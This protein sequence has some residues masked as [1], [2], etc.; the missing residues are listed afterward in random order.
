[1]ATPAFGSDL[2]KL[3]YLIDME[4]LN[5]LGSPLSL[6]QR[7]VKLTGSVPSVA[8]TFVD[9][10]VPE[11]V[12]VNLTNL[13]LSVTD[14]VQKAMYEAMTQVTAAALAQILQ[15]L[16]ITTPN[17]TTMADLLNPYILFP[18]SFQSLTVPTMNGPRAIYINATGSVNT[19]LGDTSVTLTALPDYILSSGV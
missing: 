19:K 1:L 3:G 15:V 6:I 12:V 17:I 16:N 7:I 5:N 10:G 2:S 13:T 9:Y 8:L 14:A 4:D 11:E 18:N